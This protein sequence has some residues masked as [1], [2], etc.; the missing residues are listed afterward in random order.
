MFVGRVH[1]TGSWW[2]PLLVVETFRPVLWS[3]LQT[4]LLGDKVPCHCF[5]GGASS[6]PLHWM[7]EL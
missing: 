1:V 6:E 3:A 2:E 7:G 5:L 4:T